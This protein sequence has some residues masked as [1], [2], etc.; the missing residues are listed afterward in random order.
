MVQMKHKHANSQSASSK[1]ASQK[2]SQISNGKA[3]NSPPR[4]VENMTAYCGECGRRW[5]ESLLQV[6]TCFHCAALIKVMKLY[7]E[8]CPHCLSLWQTKGQD[9]CR[10]CSKNR[11]E[12]VETSKREMIEFKVCANPGCQT[13]WSEDW[14]DICR[15]CGHNGHPNIERQMGYVIEKTPQNESNNDVSEL[16]GFNSAIEKLLSPEQRI[17]IPSPIQINQQPNLTKCW[18]CLKKAPTYK[19]K[20]LNYRCPN[21]DKLN[22]SSAADVVG[23]GGSKNHKGNGVIGNPQKYLVI[24]NECIQEMPGESFSFGQKEISG[25]FEAKL[26]LTCDLCEEIG[27][28]MFFSVINTRD[29]D[30]D[31]RSL[32]PYAS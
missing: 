29:L 1:H 2:A 21:C 4:A 6:H 28:H 15:S 18:H 30:H 16:P 19:F 23:V 5:K 14:G 12:P 17:A 27:E 8:E 10:I 22:R 31:G 11:T 13:L 9:I 7:A 20:A 25:N 26:N 3:T 24:C 32:V